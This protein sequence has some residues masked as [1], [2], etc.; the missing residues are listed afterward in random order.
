MYFFIFLKAI[1]K[2]T[3]YIPK[4]KNNDELYKLY[5]CISRLVKQKQDS[6]NK[7]F[8]PYIEGNV[9]TFYTFTSATPDR[10][11]SVNFLNEEWKKK[12][13]KNEE[14]KEVKKGTIFKLSF[15][16]INAYDIHLFNYFG[17]YEILLEP[18]IKYEINESEKFNE[19]INLNCKILDSTI[20]LKDI[21]EGKNKKE[22][23]KMINIK[24]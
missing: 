14:T 19:I 21:I 4:K 1:R 17:E 3:K 12:N 15:K 23:G 8:I 24:K 18:E 11:I 9:K 7:K 6:K 16:Q 5:K 22:K 13:S 20:V 2:L 10:D